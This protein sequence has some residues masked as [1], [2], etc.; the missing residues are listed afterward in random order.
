MINLSNK[1][2]IKITDG[3]ET[4]LDVEIVSRKLKKKD[5]REISQLVADAQKE[6]EENPLDALDEI[7][8]AAKIRF[9]KQIT[10]APKDIKTLKE[11]GDDY[12]YTGLITE[13]DAQVKESKSKAK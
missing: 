5:Q 2:Q 6:V 11:F 8:E 1:I 12:G 3:E 10:G 9:E 13:I 4:L 7:E